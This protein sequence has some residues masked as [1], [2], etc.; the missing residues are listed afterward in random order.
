MKPKNVKILFIGQSDLTCPRNTILLKGLKKNRIDDIL[1][2]N[3]HITIE[4]L[5][6]ENDMGLSKIIRRVLRR[7]R[8]L[9]ELITKLAVLKKFDLIFV[10]YPGH[11]DIPIA[12][13]F[14]KILHKPLIFDPTI[15]L[16]SAFSDDLGSVKKS[17]LK[18]KL[19]TFVEKVIYKLP[20]L[21]LA[22]TPQMAESLVKDFGVNPEKIRIVPLG[23]DEEIY[24]YS[25]YT[26]K[27]KLNVVYYG[28]YNIVHGVEYIIETARL[29]KKNN[30]INFLM[31]GKGRTYPEA[32]D[33]ADRYKLKNVIFYPEITEKNALQTLQDSDIFLGFVKDSPTVRRAI[34]NKVL[35][36]MALGRAVLTAD[37]PV[38]RHFFKDGFNIKLCRASN[39]ESLA[40]SIVEL[41]NPRIRIKIAENGRKIFLDQFS[42]FAVGKKLSLILDEITKLV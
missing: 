24:Q 22:D 37:T 23:A 39:S 17:S 25:K 10:G 18:M 3:K 4:N 33:L 6:S 29:L 40:E 27:D 1:V 42:T 32:K 34:P 15:I 13:I 35:Q 7:L 30:N 19:V 12:N 26:P 41:S 28:V 2:I 38:M 20:T 31:I 36:G 9:P 14:A 11:L 5:T 16:S 8:L 21:V